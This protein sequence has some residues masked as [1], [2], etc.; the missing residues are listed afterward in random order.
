MKRLIL[1]AVLGCASDPQ[2]AVD[3]YAEALTSA[4]TWAMGANGALTL[5][6]AE[7][8]VLVTYAPAEA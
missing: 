1:L 7:G 2:R 3:A 4:A 8:A 6:S 5:L